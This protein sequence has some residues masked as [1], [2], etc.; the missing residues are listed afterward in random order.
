MATTID[1]KSSINVKRLT[2]WNLET[3]SKDGTTYATDPYTFDHQLNSV[4]VTPTVAM[5]EQRGDGVKVEDFVAK[6][7]GDIDIIIRGFK[8]GDSA[9]LFG[10][11]AN[12]DGV[13]VSNTGDIVPYKCV[14]WC[15]E[16][17]DGL[18]NLY[19]KPKVKWMPQGQDDKQREGTTISYG[20]AA[21]KGTYSPLMSNGDDGY[22]MLG[23]NPKAQGSVI[24]A[25]FTTAAYTAPTTT[26]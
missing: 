18:L 2:M 6:D 10:E 13:E 14:A 7:G 21:L 5:A 17:A 3:D 20:T 24:D 4:K 25:W 22:Q 19:K 16:R 23:V 26:I 11:T 12:S 15:T 9:Y 1:G 8:P